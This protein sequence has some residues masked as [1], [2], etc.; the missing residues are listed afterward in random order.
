[1]ADVG[2]LHRNATCW[3][4]LAIAVDDFP[5]EQWAIRVQLRLH[6]RDERAVSAEFLD[7]HSYQFKV[8][9]SPLGDAM[10]FLVSMSENINGAKAVA[11]RA[12]FKFFGGAKS[13]D[14]G[15]LADEI[16]LSVAGRDEDI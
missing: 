11:A 12:N 10:I 6:I 8:R 15:G 9:T 13:M 1:M 2:V 3:H 4:G 7:S 5:D 14:A 16:A